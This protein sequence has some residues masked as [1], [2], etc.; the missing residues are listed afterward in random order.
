MKIEN[1]KRPICRI[2]RTQDIFSRSNCTHHNFLIKV[3]CDT[4]QDI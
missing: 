4:I 3:L 1:R 2:H